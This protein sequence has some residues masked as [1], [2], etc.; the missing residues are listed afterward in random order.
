[1]KVALVGNMNNGMFA[2]ARHLRDRGL[3]AELFFS[4]GF[5][6][7]H[8]KADTYDLADLEYCREVT[9]LQSGFRAVEGGAIRRD[10]RGSD[11]ILATGDE[12]AA[13][14]AVG[15]PID[16]YFPYGDDVLRWAHPSLRR[17]PRDAALEVVAAAGRIV[18]IR[19]ASHPRSVRAAI[20]SARHL[21][22]DQMNPTCD[23][24]MLSLPIGGTI[25]RSPWPFLHP[26]SYRNALAA[27]SVPDVHWRS[28][29]DAMRARHDFVLLYH[30]RHSWTRAGDFNA[31]NTHHVLIGF[32]E[33]VRRH[34]DVDAC[35]ATIEY[36]KDVRASKELIAELGIEERVA[37]FP[38]MFRKDLMYLISRADLCCGEFA[39]SYLTFGTILEALCLGKPVVHHRDD[40]L[41]AGPL[42]PVL[43]AREPDE[44]ASALDACLDDPESCRRMGLEGQAWVE[45]HVVERPLELIFSLLGM[46]RPAAGEHDSR[47]GVAL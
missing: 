32:A 28:A 13:L 40:S 15:V 16:V 18:P 5:E 19:A 37:W 30:G 9:W 41:Y 31:K 25:H 1:M 10:L 38:V 46:P 35:L 43:N 45:E 8:P 36:G 29:V 44:I 2:L 12:A 17:S 33:F 3:D 4:R 24:I 23:R 7:F 20:C 34:P 14:A 42:Y 27:G 21:V 47:V 26:A 22:V 39:E 11:A 6:H